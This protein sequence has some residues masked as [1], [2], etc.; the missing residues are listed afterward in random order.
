[1]HVFESESPSLTIDKLPANGAGEGVLWGRSRQGRR[2]NNRPRLMRLV[3]DDVGWL[4]CTIWTLLACLWFGSAWSAEPSPRILI[5]SD[6]ADARLLPAPSG[7]SRKAQLE[8]Q[9]HGGV[10]WPY[11]VLRPEGDS[12]QWNTAT[13]LLLPISN[14]TSDAV[15]LFLRLGDDA[16]ASWPMHAIAAKIFIQPHQTTTLAVALVAHDP[17]QMGMRASP[18]PRGAPMTGMTF[19]PDP[20]GRVDR[21]HVRSLYLVIWGQLGPRRLIVG[22]PQPANFDW[23]AA[24]FTHLIDRYGQ[25]TNVS[26]PDKV[27]SD[28]DLRAQAAR[29][30]RQLAMWQTDLPAADRFGGLEAASPSRAT[31]FFRTQRASDGRW[32]LVTP[33]GHSF[34][35]I[36][37]NAVSAAGGATYVEGREFM[38]GDLPGPNQ[39]LDRYFGTSVGPTSAPAQAAL[40]FHQG[41]WFNFYEANLERKYGSGKSGSFASRAVTRLRAWGFN[42]IGNWSAPEVTA[43]HKM[44]YVLGISVDGDFARVPTAGDYW[45]AMPDPFD[46][47]FGAVLGAAFQSQSAGHRDDAWLIGYFVDNELPWGNGQSPDPRLRYALAVSCLTLSA[48]SPAKRAFIAELRE[49][50][51]SIDRLALAW[52]IKASS[53]QQLVTAP[54]VLPATL[55]APCVADLMRFSDHFAETYYR[56]VHDVTKRIDPNHLYLGSRFSA[57]TPEALHACEHWCD[58]VSFNMYASSYEASRHDRFETLTKPALISEFNFSSTDRGPPWP[59]LV[60]VGSEERRGPAYAAYLAAAS[61]DPAVVGVQWF[62]YLDE[63]TTG[64]LLDGEN[65][66]FG[67]VSV[68]DTPYREFVAAVRQ[69]NVAALRS[70]S[71][72]AP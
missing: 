43:L 19:I 67:L 14:P 28:T 24:S 36:G 21:Q 39:A 64:R 63:P 8:V 31:G 23:G 34:F 29:E 35:S 61:A 45:N 65:A 51:G 2:G 6:G 57:Q 58:V 37:V 32:W 72:N 56:V 3:I 25:A 59:G 11:V 18:P 41:R 26:W 4:R 5:R 68:T 44:P 16:E 69:A 55:S 52:K 50:Y 10:D 30:S 38:F 70:R 20:S 17:R 33:E 15:Q 53:W 46:P 12:A 40:G 62:Q 60:D 47:R 1:M 7:G 54:V 49:H 71:T 48:A 13:T 27:A 22:E 42:T 9:Y 66:H